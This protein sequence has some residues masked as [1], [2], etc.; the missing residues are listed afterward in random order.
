MTENASR[1][2]RFFSLFH[3]ALIPLVLLLA[4]GPSVEAQPGGKALR[5][6]SGR[7]DFMRVPSDPSLD[8]NAFTICLWVR[9]EAPLLDQHCVLGRSAAGV[10]MSNGL[11]LTYGY[12][13]NDA[14]TVFI[15]GNPFT[16]SR[17]LPLGRWVHLAVVYDGA[18]VVLYM[19]GEEEV[20]AHYV[21]SLRWDSD[22]FFG[23][24]MDCANGCLD[25]RQAFAGMVDDI[26][27][28]AAPRSRAQVHEDMLS[29]APRD[30]ANLV[31][32]W[33]LE[34]MSGPMVHDLS[35]AENHA[36]LGIP[37][38]LPENLPGEDLLPSRVGVPIHGNVDVR[39]NGPADVLRVNRSTGDLGRFLT[40][41]PDQDIVIS[42]N[43]PP[44]GP[45][46]APFALYLHMGGTTRATRQ[47][48]DVGWTAFPTPFSGGS[49]LNVV[50]LVN[51]LGPF[52]RFGIPLHR[53]GPAPTSLIFSRRNVAIP[54]TLCL[55]ALISDNGAGN[56]SR[57]SVSNSVDL[58]IE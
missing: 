36:L 23:V 29:V 34:E 45:S 8:G 55:Q 16:G 33:D 2:S 42:V 30:R 27:F 54:L 10:G 24:E 50:T 51:N 3:H 7:N 57:L 12:L 20:R 1:S 9:R 15:D 58:R 4:T 44:H 19:N 22:L 25:R 49:T 28:W 6:E 26:R 47:P 43:S 37:E 52:S 38:G 48:L 31:G 40:V 18:E 32:H 13:G 5:F 39:F 35:G 17:P 56:P 46:R 14:F 11:V 21:Q 53:R 41:P